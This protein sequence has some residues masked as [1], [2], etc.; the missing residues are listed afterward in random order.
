MRVPLAR[1]A[2]G[3]PF[4]VL[5]LALVATAV[6]P[7][8][9][10]AQ[11]V[12]GV[13]TEAGTNRPLP[14]V[15]VVLTDEAGRQ[16]AGVLTSP[17]GRFFLRA[18]RPGTYRLTAELIGYASAEEAPFT[19][20][21]GESLRRDI[22]VS[23]EAV[24][25]DEIRVATGERCRAR[26]GSGPET[27]RLWEE[28]R[29]ALEIARWSEEEGYLRFQVVRHR[30]E[31]DARTMRVV[32]QEESGKVGLYD[33]SPFVSIP[34]DRLDSGG[35]IQAVSDGT[36]DYFAPD[37]EVL[38]SETF[39]DNHCFRAA[40]PPPGEPDLIGLAFEP[41]PGRDLPDISGVLWLDR[42]SAELRRLDY[43]YTKLPF[44]DESWPQV[45]GRVEF[46]RL[47]TGMWVVRRWHVRMPLAATGTGGF[48]GGR[49]EIDLVSLI[50]EGGEIRS[51]STRSGQVLAQ[52][53]GATV[54]GTVTAKP[55]GDPL[56]GAR[57]EISPGTAQTTTGEDGAFR[58]TDLPAGTFTLRVFHPD[59]EL[60][61]LSPT[62]QVAELAP[63]RATRAPVSV[64]LSGDR[65]RQ[66]CR[67][68]GWTP[69]GAG[70]PVLLYG[71]VRAASS[72]EVVP[73]AVVRVASGAPERRVVADST[74]TYRLCILPEGGA[75]RVGAVAPGDVA[76]SLAPDQIVEAR[77]EQPGFVRADVTLSRGAMASRSGTL[78]ARDV[79]V[80][81]VVEHGTGQPVPAATITLALPDDRAVGNAVTDGEGRF[82]L[83]HPGRGDAY[84]LRV[85][86][87][88]YSPV[89][90]TLAFPSGEEVT[91]DIVLSTQAIALEGIVVRDRRRTFL[92]SQGF[93]DRVER[94]T[95]LYIQREEIERRRPTKITDLIAGRPGI[96]VISSWTGLEYDMR[97]T[98]RYGGENCQP[99]IYLDGVLI[100][101]GG[102]RTE[103]DIMLSQVINPDHVEAMEVY[104]S[105]AGMPIQFA[106]AASPCGAV[107]IWSRRD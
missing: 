106:G 102:D 76:A 45:G 66:I 72:D 55:T 80:G 6:G 77:V 61:G 60:L 17:E 65:A 20:A 39:L 101:Y 34:A 98:Q 64:D 4:L 23:V 96:N 13:V 36:W 54:Y 29:K 18:G 81:K 40:G 70:E 37:A 90:S 103:G 92:A 58:I 95:G 41:V 67:A 10:R 57:V 71:R 73:G 9:V 42:G 12:G 35:Y 50:E 79:L 85:E 16:A 46:E 63:A 1:P 38:L 86:H 97:L 94:G 31:L 62:E 2:A 22:A 89:E 8:Q 3:N 7:D 32:K 87:I 47:A 83:T 51:V 88:A 84:T 48:G 26:P 91:L 93:Y 107:A 25:L 82:K 75:V 104:I 44:T 14:G 15:F 105:A 43:S 74:G 19:L 69:S 100:R 30:R 59:M 78:S 68:G 49:R 5:I 99:S 24:S 28:A 27:A 53:V 52:A 11:T 33:H 56:P 21:A